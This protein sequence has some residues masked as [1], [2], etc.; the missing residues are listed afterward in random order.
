MAPVVPAG[1]FAALPHV[2]YYAIHCINALVH[3]ETSIAGS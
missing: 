2:M 1:L 3:Y